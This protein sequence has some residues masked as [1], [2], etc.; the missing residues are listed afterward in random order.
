M[1]HSSAFLLFAGSFSLL[2]SP[3]ISQQPL[4]PAVITISVFPGDDIGAKLAHAMAACNPN[5]AVPCVLEIDAPLSGAPAGVLPVLCPQCSLRDDRSPSADGKLPDLLPADTTVLDA[6]YY[7]ADPTGAFDSTQA[8]SR[9]AAASCLSSFE[10]EPVRLSPGIYRLANL[11]LSALHCAPYFETPN[12]DSVQ[13]VYNGDGSSGDYLIKLPAMSFGGFRGIYFDGANPATGALATYGVWLSSSVDNGFWIQRARF[14]NFLSHAIYQSPAAFTNWHMDHLRFDS[15]GG[16]G[17]YITGGN[18]NDGQPFTLSNFTV[19]NHYPGG[20]AAK[21]L[22][23]KGLGNGTNW[24]DAVVCVDNG[25]GI[26]LDLEGA[27]IE[28]NAPQIPIGNNDNGSLVREWNTRPGQALTINVH[29]VVNLGSPLNSAMVASAH[30]QVRLIVS[31]SGGAN[32]SA[33]VKNVATQTY[34]GDKYCAQDGLF[35]WGYNGQQEG[36]L[37][38]GSAGSIPSKIDALASSQLAANFAT[39]HAGDVILHPNSEAAPG[40][41]GALRWVTAPLDGACKMVAQP[42]ASDAIVRAG[43]PAISFPQGT[44]LSSLQILPGD[45]IVIEGAGVSGGNLATQVVSASFAANTIT[46]DPVPQ[47]SAASAKIEWQTCT[48]HELPGAQSANSPPSSGTWATG[49]KV[50]NT[51]IAE[52]QPIFWA[53]AAGGT[54]CK[55]WVSGP[56]Y[57]PAAP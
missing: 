54:P 35:V 34:Y 48:L 4:A 25:T 30:G 27:R 3:A 41:Q 16:C 55:K 6:R 21:W 24:G 53:C 10:V 13:L 37:S 39:F 5:P 49:E 47:A 23:G 36:G 15:V 32:T 18:T 44:A 8:L 28:L 20:K 45:D 42:I 7:G 56:A 1:R 33:C 52:G 2:S 17:V 9:A 29:G 40:R 14:A 43:D 50:W 51:N 46:V 19:D 12:D 31:G 26:L 38:I 22:A 57:G 11:N